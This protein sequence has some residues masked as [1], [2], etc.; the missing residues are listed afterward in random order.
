MFLLSPRLWLRVSD[1]THQ[2]NNLFSGTAVADSYPSFNFRRRSYWRTSSV[3]TSLLRQ[4]SALR[5]PSAGF[6]SQTIPFLG[7]DVRDI[8]TDAIS[9]RQFILPFGA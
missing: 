2:P 9:E 6:Q 7:R 3:T 5:S 1:P 4:S 8:S